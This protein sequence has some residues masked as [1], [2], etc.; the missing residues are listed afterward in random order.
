MSQD[1]LWRVTDDDQEALVGES[2]SLGMSTRQKGT[3]IQH[4]DGTKNHHAYSSTE[5]LELEFTFYS[6]Y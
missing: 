5:V 3:S 4:L 1:P 6:R 2:S